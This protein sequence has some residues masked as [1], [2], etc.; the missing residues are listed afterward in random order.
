MREFKKRRSKRDEIVH[1]GLRCLYTLA[2]LA[3]TVVLMRA[4]WGMYIKMVAASRAQEEAQ[5]QLALTEAQR[6]GVD[7][8]LG[9]VNSPRGVEQQIRERYGVVRPGEGEIDIVRTVPA[10]T[11][12]KA[13]PESWWQ[14][15][16]HALFVW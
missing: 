8:T 16:F 12:P 10:S 14:H 5:A 6:S 2:L 11:T 3:V 9:E 1:V 15:I 4:A 7:A 13:P